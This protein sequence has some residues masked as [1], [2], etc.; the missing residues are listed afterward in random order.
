M[1]EFILRSFEEYSII[2]II[3][4]AGIGGLIGSLID[5]IFN[6]LITPKLQISRDSKA[7]IKKYRYPILR[8][9]DTLDRRLE[10]LIKFVD[11]K[12]FDDPEDDYYRLSTLY[13]MG[14]Y[15]G[16]SK[17][18]EDEAFLEYELSNKKAK[19]FSIQFNR[20]FKGLTGF[21]YFKDVKD[22][23]MS[24]IKQ[25]SVPRLALTAIG[26][27]MLKKSKSEDGMPSVLD[28]VEF[29]RQY[30]SS[31]DFKRWFGYLEQLL[32]DLKRDG[33]DA[34]WNRLVVFASN[35]RGFVAFLD[36]DGRQTSR[37]RIDYLDPLNP[38]VHK[39][40][41]DELAKSGFAKI[42]DTPN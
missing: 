21:Y 20:V 2:W 24:D 11:R 3:I 31:P 40:L 42:L 15:F 33:N 37:R 38:K 4:S 41:T 1:I 34:K 16:W 5:F 28:F 27:L 14:C 12:W 10:N 36:K 8:S 17:V 13:L 29:I 7:A 22:S 18:L 26:E 19:Q 39:L 25:A 9:A 32:S 35:L 23:E 30:E 6:Q